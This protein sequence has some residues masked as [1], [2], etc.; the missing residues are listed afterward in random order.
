MFGEYMFFFVPQ[1][2]GISYKVKIDDCSAEVFDQQSSKWSCGESNPGPN[3]DSMYFYCH[4]QC[5]F[6]PSRQYPLTGSAF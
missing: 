1:N 3:P 6:V 2:G 4:S 5:L